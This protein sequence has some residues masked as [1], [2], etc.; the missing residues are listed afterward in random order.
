MR[1][2]KRAAGLETS[3][4]R[5]LFGKAKQYQDVIDLTLGDPDL[6]PSELI[7]EAAC[8][9][10]RQGKTRYSVNAGLPEARRQIAD[11]FA[12][13][14]GFSPDPEKEVMLTV[15]GMGGLYLSLAALVDPGDEVLVLGPY[16]VNYIQMIR[17]CGGTPK[18]VY[19]REENGFVV[20]KEE[21]EAEVTPKTVAMIV[22]S[23]SNPAG[24]VLERETLEDYADFARAHG[25]FVLSDEVYQTLLYDG[26]KPV[27]IINCRD[28]RER[29]VVIESM[30]KRFAMTGYRCGFAV[31]PGPLIAAMTKMQENIVSCTPLPSQYAAICAYSRCREDHHIRDEFE[32]RR[33]YIFEA[34]NEIPGLSCLK[35]A[36]TFYLFVNIKESG[37]DSVSFAYRL[38]EQEHLAIVPG[39][40][41][42]QAYDHYIRIAFTLPVE[43]LKEA[44]R[45]LSRFMAGLKN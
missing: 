29:C 36:G 10:I 28:M 8:E 35:P 14:Y 7:R 26:R 2:S 1:L 23:P 27:S 17:L 24:V 19:G 32:K 33:N 31:G 12:G 11:C 30:S 40:T 15:G 41:Y 22:N 13:E 34:V 6:M 42:G 45:R 38:L 25:L 9:A 20:K 39:V 18:I 16:Y 44:V 37:M 43:V 21:L 4:T 5:E 3:L